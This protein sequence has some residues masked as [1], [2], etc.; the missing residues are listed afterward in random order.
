[1]TK[2]QLRQQFLAQRNRLSPV[3]IVEK[4]QVISQTFFTT[5]DLNIKYLHLFLPILRKNEVNTW[6]IIEEIQKN[7]PKIQ[8]I[9]PKS[10]LSTGQME[11]YLL[12]K[13]TKIVENHWQ[14]PEPVE[15]VPCPNNLIDMILIPLLCFDQQGFRVGYGKGFYDRFLSQCRSDVIKVGLSFFEPVDAIDDIHHYDIKMDFCIQETHIF[16]F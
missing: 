10:Q 3:E 5:F 7:H 8:L 6:F 14:I 13:N 15:A 12:E 16:A 4:S 9:V 2:H 1:M 11:N